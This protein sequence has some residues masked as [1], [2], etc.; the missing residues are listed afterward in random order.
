MQT[1]LLGVSTKY[2]DLVYPPIFTGPARLG[3]ADLPKG[4]TVLIRKT[5]RGTNENEKGEQGQKFIK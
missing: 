3:C 1:P 5:W 4:I 2:I